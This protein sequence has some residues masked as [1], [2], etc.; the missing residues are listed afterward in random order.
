MS[1]NVTVRLDIEFSRL[2]SA[3][4]PCLE[5]TVSVPELAVSIPLQPFVGLWPL[6]QFT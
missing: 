1:A 3:A 6:F 5:R 4:S 2:E